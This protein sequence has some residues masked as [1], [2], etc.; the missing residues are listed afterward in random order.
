[1]C[2]WG[3][4]GVWESASPVKG[5]MARSLEILEGLGTESL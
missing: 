5:Q 4:D 2:V 1:M 3:G